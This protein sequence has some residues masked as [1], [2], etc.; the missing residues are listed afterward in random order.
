[1]KAM[2]ID[3]H[4]RIADDDERF[5]DVL[6]AA[7]IADDQPDDERDYDAEIHQDAR[8]AIET[9][10]QIPKVSVDLASRARGLILVIDTMAEI[11]KL[12]GFIKSHKADDPIAVEERIGT[13]VQQMNVGLFSASGLDAMVSA[14]ELTRQEAQDEFVQIRHGMRVAYTGPENT[15]A[16]TRYIRNLT[17]IATSWR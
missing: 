9:I 2:D 4:S 11:S 13:L 1:M 16:R 5:G 7:D 17:K 15:N 8:D 3:P 6:P 10:K 14:G 12:R